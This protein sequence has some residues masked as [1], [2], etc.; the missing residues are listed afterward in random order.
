M[1]KPKTPAPDTVAALVR[2]TVDRL[3][4]TDSQAADYFGVPVFTVRKWLTGE[5]EPGAA[6]ARLVEVLGLVEA[7]A[8]SLHSSL[9]PAVAV[10][11]KRSPK[12]AT[13]S[14]HVEK[15]ENLGAPTL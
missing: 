14:R 6:V 9:V 10:K 2:A 5:R 8:P 3:T 15:S 7:L 4:L 1:N 13:E 12:F 11:P